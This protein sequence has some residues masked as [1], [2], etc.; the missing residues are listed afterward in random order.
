M[1]VCQSCIRYACRTYVDYAYI[2][3]VIVVMHEVTVCGQYGH[4]LIMVEMM[5]M[6]WYA[7][8]YTS[9]V[10]IWLILQVRYHP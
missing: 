4:A 3:M 6:Y 2:H 8:V 10:L 5:F 7:Y 9:I 1:H